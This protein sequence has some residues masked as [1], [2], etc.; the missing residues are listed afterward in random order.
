MTKASPR[1]ETALI[2][3]ILK[4]YLSDKL[5]A[6]LMGI[7]DTGNGR[8]ESYEHIPMPRMTNTI[9][10]AGPNDPE[11]IMSCQARGLREEVWRRPGRHR[12]RRLRLLADRE[13]PVEDGKITAPLKGVNLIGNGPDVLRG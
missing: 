3:K 8:R 1:E 11:E 6:R 12:Q 5:S 7:A 2:E 10:L 4:G 13:L 9:L